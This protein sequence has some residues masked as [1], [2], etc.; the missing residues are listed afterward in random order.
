MTYALTLVRLLPL[1]FF[2]RLAVAL[3]EI[4]VA[5]VLVSG[6]VV[7][8]HEL[9]DWRA[10][11]ADPG[12]EHPWAP[13][14]KPSATVDVS[15]SSAVAPQTVATPQSRWAATSRVRWPAATANTMRARRTW[16]QGKQSL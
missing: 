14:P 13:T 7:L 1:A 5:A 4:A 8:G 15:S 10:W 9:N 2:G 11:Y 12:T 6:S 3:S 16:Y